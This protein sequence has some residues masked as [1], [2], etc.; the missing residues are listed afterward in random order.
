MRFCRLRTRSGVWQLLDKSGQRHGE[1]ETVIVSAPS[2]QSAQTPGSRPQK[3]AGIGFRCEDAAVLG[4]HG[5]FWIVDSGHHLMGPL[6]MIHHC[7][8]SPATRANLRRPR[9]QDCW[10]FQGSADWSRN[11]IDVSAED[12]ADALLSEFWE[13]NGDTARSAHIPHCSSLAIRTAARSLA[14]S[15]PV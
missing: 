9:V 3:L 4:G 1:F 6:S 11:H 10:V 2:T 15:V 8:G 13:G 5:S 14:R 7:L 12:V